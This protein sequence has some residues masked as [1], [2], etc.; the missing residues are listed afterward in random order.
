MLLVLAEANAFT[1]GAATFLFV[2]IVVGLVYGGYKVFERL[3][4]PKD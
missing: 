3:S 2:M 1:K 4:G